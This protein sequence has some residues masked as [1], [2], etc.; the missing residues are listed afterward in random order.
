MDLSVIFSIVFTGSIID[1]VIAITIVAFI[2]LAVIIAFFVMTSRKHGSKQLTEIS[3]LQ[4]TQKIED[5]YIGVDMTPTTVVG[6]TGVA[7]TDLRPSGKIT[8]GTIDY[9]AVALLDFI[10]EGTEV[11][12][13]KYENAQL[14]V[15]AKK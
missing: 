15:K 4:A 10:D 6:K 2:I 14:Y 1:W 8:V 5:G 13:E 9:D 3:E 11:V 12:V 7:L